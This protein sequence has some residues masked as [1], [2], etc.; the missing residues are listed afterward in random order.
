MRNNDDF[1][2]YY[3]GDRILVADNDM[4]NKFVCFEPSV[5]NPKYD[6]LR[7]STQI[8][9]ADKNNPNASSDGFYLYLFKVDAPGNVPKD[10]YL[11]AEFNH[12]GYGRTIPMTMPNQQSGDITYA[13]PYTSST[14]PRDYITSAKY[15]DG[16]TGGTKFD[17]A[18]YAQNIYIPIKTIYDETAKKYYYYFPWDASVNRIDERKIVLNLYEPKLNKSE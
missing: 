5:V 6:S 9:L 7:L 18:K 12:A 1:I 3:N 17:Y 11:A 2:N 14:F 15:A 10:M 13:I 16:T 4:T 8:V